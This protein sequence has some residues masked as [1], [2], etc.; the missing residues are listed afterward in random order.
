MG[1]RVVSPEEHLI[2]L[3][4]NNGLANITR[5]YDTARESVERTMEFRQ[6]LSRGDIAVRPLV[7]LLE[8]PGEEGVREILYML[9]L[10]LGEDA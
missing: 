4:F 10:L 5:Y 3:L 2:I 1:V 8:D 7:L 6:I 9:T